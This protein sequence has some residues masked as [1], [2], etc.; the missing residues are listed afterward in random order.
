MRKRRKPRRTRRRMSM[1][2]GHLYDLD[3]RSLTTLALNFLP[4][5]LDASSD[6]AGY[7]LQTSNFTPT[8]GSVT[9]V[10]VKNADTTAVVIKLLLHKFKVGNASSIRSF[11]SICM[12]T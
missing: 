4:L 10:R 7:L 6:Y 5:I 9:T 1:I 3:V 12:Y 11:S 8:N 2:N